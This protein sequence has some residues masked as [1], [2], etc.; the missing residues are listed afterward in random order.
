MR[1]EQ[2]MYEEKN[3]RLNELLSSSKDDLIIDEDENN[4]DKRSF[5]Y[6]STTTFTSYSFFTT[7]VTKTVRL[8]TAGTTSGLTCLPCNFSVCR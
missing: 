6:A 8:L 3:A 7:T 5:F 1:S 4:R 2:E